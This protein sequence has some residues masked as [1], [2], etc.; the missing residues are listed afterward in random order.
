MLSNSEA[1]TGIESFDAVAR[2]DHTNRY[3]NQLR[4]IT[5]LLRSSF[6]FIIVIG[7]T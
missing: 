1:A 2:I 7:F 4:N 6:R 5:V 3:D